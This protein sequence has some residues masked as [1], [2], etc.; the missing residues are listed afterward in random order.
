MLDVL[1]ESIIDASRHEVASYASDPDNAPRWYANISS[2]E[3]VTPPPLRPGTRLAFVARFLGRR[4]AYTY[5]VVDFVPD[6]R[7]VMSTSEG[8]FPM[9]TTYEWADDRPGRTRMTLRNR[10]SPRGLLRLLAPV[11]A[12]AVRSANRNDLKRLRSILETGGD[13]D[14]PDR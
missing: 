14:P 8:P 13:H 4:L 12:A 2:V 10:G 5:E 3:W 9:E 11:M 7:L 6:R 1:T